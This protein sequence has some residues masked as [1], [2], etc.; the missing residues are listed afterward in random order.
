MAKPKIDPLLK[1]KDSQERDK[2]YSKLDEHQK[3][4]YNCIIDKSV[5]CVNEKSGT[6]KTSVATLAALNL[7]GE[8]KVNKIVYLRFPDE[9]SLRLG[10]LPG[11]LEDKQSYYMYPFYEACIECGLQPEFVDS[12]VAEGLIEL[13]TDLGM[14]GRNLKNV[15]LI[16]DESQNGSLQD[17]K[18]VLTRL[19]DDS[20]CVLIGH[21]GQIDSDMQLYNGKT[22]FELYIEHLCKKPWAIQCELPI[23][24][25]GKISKWCDELEVN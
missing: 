12:L 6:G 11:E 8:N 15:F 13:T 21:T 25:R 4:Y 14:R 9:R 2:L 18:L 1:L 22:A 7:L 24:Y 17:L 19:H 16:I 5:T 10:F 23:N 20:K 3:N